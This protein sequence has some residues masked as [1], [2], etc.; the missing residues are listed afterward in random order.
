MY[1]QDNNNNNYEEVSNEYS[2]QEPT[3]TS[4]VVNQSETSEESVETFSPEVEAE[5]LAT[6]TN[7]DAIEDPQEPYKVTALIDSGSW[8][9]FDSSARTVEEFLR[10]RGK[11]PSTV[12]VTSA[13]TG[14]FVSNDSQM[15]PDDIYSIIS[16]NKTGG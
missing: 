10:E 11:D 3:E 1:M 5:V 13:N 16:R 9:T 7:L 6:Q 8:E 4:E 14:G 15:D 2:P 12:E